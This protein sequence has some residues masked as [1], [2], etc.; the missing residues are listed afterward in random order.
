MHKFI[1]VFLLLTTA[2]LCNAAAP[3]RLADDSELHTSVRQTGS[4]AS[5]SGVAG[6]C[7]NTSVY[8]CTRSTLTGR[9]PGGASIRCC[10]RPGG[11]RSS[12]CGTGLCMRTSDCPRS[13]L[14]GRCPGPSGITCCPAGRPVPVPVPGPPRPPV[15]VP[16]C[17]SFVASSSSCSFYKNIRQNGNKV[18]VGGR[19]RTF[20]VTGR[21][22]FTRSYLT[23]AYCACDTTPKNQASARTIRRCLQQ[24]VLDASAR[25][26]TM[27]SKT[28]IENDHKICYRAGG[29]PCGPAFG[30]AW[31]IVTS[32]PLSEFQCGLVSASIKVFGRCNQCSIFGRR[33]CAPCL[34]GW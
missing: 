29:C 11:V 17:R 22:K 14:T 23:N 34:P 19:W 18:C 8:S 16:Q 7:I 20:R 5:C 26:K 28:D 2:C 13:T 33:V 3:R 4:W 30:G 6:V 10:P 12:A 31:H 24:R 25:G 32:L 21:L 15:P 1:S 27:W 9:C